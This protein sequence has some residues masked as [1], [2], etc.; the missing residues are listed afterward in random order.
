[1]PRRSTR[2]RRSVITND[3]ILYLQEHE[4]GIGLEDGPTSLNEAKLFIH[5][6]ELSNVM[7]NE[8]KSMKDNDVG[9]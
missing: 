8:L 7:K 5:S 3:Y 1:M 2:E 9:I 4:F 6:T